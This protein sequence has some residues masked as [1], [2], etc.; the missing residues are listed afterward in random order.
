[1]KPIC[2]K[3]CE[4]ANQLIYCNHDSGK[5]CYTNC[6]LYQQQ[7]ELERNIQLNDIGLVKVVNENTE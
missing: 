6:E 1:M 3:P 4:I 7:V 5:Y 2:P